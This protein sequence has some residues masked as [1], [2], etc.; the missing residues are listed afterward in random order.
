LYWWALYRKTYFGAAF[1]PAALFALFSKN[2]SWQSVLGGMLTGTI[3]LV[4]W[5]FLGLSNYCYEIVPGFIANIITIV[6][7]NKIYPAKNPAITADFAKMKK[8][9][10]L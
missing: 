1:G 9:V 3:S 7:L 4:L 2:T 5:K 6:V 10:Q 8:I